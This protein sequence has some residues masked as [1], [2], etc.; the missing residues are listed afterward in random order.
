MDQLVIDVTKIQNI[1]QGDIVT[2]IGEE[3]KI[4]VEEIA[5]KSDTITNEL[6]CRLGDRLERVNCRQSIY[7]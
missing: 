6:L 2:L 7:K 5:S 4:S 3:E 1:N